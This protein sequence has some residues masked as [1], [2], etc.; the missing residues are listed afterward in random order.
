MVERTYSTIM[1]VHCTIIPLNNDK[2]TFQ[3]N[4]RDE[5]FNSNMKSKFGLRVN[6]VFIKQ[7]IAG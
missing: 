4:D 6:Y 5:K 1:P 2:I 3:A 7:F